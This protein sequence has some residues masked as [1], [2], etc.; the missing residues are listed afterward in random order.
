MAKTKLNA[1]RI[2]SLLP[3]IMR[4]LFQPS[5][6]D[7]ISD[8]PLAQ[9]RLMRILHHASYSGTEISAELNISA[10]AFCQLSH[11][12]EEAGLLTS[13]V[14]GTD[15]RVKRH[16]L[17]EKGQAFMDQRQRDRVSK[18]QAVLETLAPEEQS[19]VMKSLELLMTACSRLHPSQP[20]EEDLKITLEMQVP[21]QAG[22]S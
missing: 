19:Q 2:E 20:A 12:L 18:A 7:P 8:L 3:Q 15:R 6:E 21:K 11:R 1:E 22:A 9:L 16:S 13:Q 5:E 10:S 17:T 4:S 14:D